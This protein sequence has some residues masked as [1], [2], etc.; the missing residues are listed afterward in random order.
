MAGVPPGG[1]GA[2]FRCLS[3]LALEELATVG[4]LHPHPTL[5]QFGVDGAA[6]APGARM[7]LGPPI[8]DFV[9]DVLEK[10]HVVGGRG[11]LRHGVVPVGSA[12]F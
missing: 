3:E 11:V 4:A 10:D 7:A 8:D 5:V 12:W 1:H 2:G 9:Q 6:A